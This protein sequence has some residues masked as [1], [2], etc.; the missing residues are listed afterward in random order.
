[1]RGVVRL[2]RPGGGWCSPTP[3][4]SQKALTEHQV[5]SQSERVA[6]TFPDTVRKEPQFRLCVNLA[7]GFGSAAFKP[8]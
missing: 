5:V 7:S 2:P 4:A 8:S 3:S 6:V 1:M